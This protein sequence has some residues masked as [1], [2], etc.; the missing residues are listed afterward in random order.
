MI[1]LQSL[2]PGIQWCYFSCGIFKTTDGNTKMKRYIYIYYKK[3]SK[4]YFEP[5]Q[6]KINPLNAVAIS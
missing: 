3:Q 6:L 2:M 4:I 5:K 1:N